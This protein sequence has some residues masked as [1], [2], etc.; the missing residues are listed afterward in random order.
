MNNLEADILDL[1]S[2]DDYGSWELWWRVTELYKAGNDASLTE[3]FVAAME[4][5]ISR[6][7]L[8]AKRRNSSGQLRPVDFSA[9]E[10]RREIK[11]AKTP[12]PDQFYWFGT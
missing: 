2:E 6:G 5:M 7:V 9:K 1:I 10:L 3:P 12:I 8:K 4:N 11:Q